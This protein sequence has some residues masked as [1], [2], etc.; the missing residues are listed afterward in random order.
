MR[1]GDPRGHV[2]VLLAG[3]AKGTFVTD[4][5]EEG[6]LRVYGPG[7][8]FGVEAVLSD[9][10]RSETVTALKRCNAILL[11]PEQFNALLARYPGIS[12]AFNRTM[13]QRVLAA[14]E[15][16]RLRHMPPEVGLARV[17]LDLARR[18]GTQTH[19]G[20]VIPVELSQ[21]DFASWLGASR[22]TVTRVLRS[23]RARG[24][25]HTGYRRI[26]ITDL[27]QLRKAAHPAW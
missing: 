20:I 1:E 7:D 13:L 19:D 14:D 25:I 24:L 5:G 11:P 18:A 22:A 12:N 15:R 26:T 16:L 4:V 23:L 9:Q 21:E 10:P 8:L 17:L 3:W 6:M 2:I 27:E